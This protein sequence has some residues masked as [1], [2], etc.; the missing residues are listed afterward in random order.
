[1]SPSSRSQRVDVDS[2]GIYNGIE[3]FLGTSKGSAL[4]YATFTPWKTIGAIAL[5]LDILALG[6]R[7]RD[8]RR[9]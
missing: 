9:M 6:G 7:K 4:R 2:T 1:T 8:R 3:L 5:I